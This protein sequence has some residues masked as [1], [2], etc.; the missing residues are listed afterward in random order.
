MTRPSRSREAA[1]TSTR[2]LGWDS[3]SLLIWAIAGWA[4]ASLLGVLL[5]LHAFL[6]RPPET[7]RV[8]PVETRMPT[9]VKSAPVVPERS[10]AEPVVEATTTTTTTAVVPARPAEPVRVASVPESMDSSSAVIAALLR[11]AA[12]FTEA[13]E[14]DEAIKAYDQALERDPGNADFLLLR[15]QVV[16]LRSMVYHGG[17]PIP[18]RV[19]ETPSVYVAPDGPGEPG[20]RQPKVGGPIRRAT[21]APEFP[22]ELVIDLRPRLIEPGDPYVL[23]VRLYNKGNRAIDVDSLE[24]VQTLGARVEGQGVANLPAV[25]RI[26]PRDTVLLWEQSGSWKEGQEAGSVA[27]NVVLTDGGTLTKSIS[28]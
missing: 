17:A 8:Q 19:R 5:A 14:F 15:A 12:D 13:G 25:A 9:P 21:Q 10:A 20:L 18:L 1:Q 11:H 28:W 16:E 24:V 27:V 7:V 23:R 26:N 3:R 6:P 4:L 2:S 22:G